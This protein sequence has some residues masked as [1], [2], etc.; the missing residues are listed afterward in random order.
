[1][2]KIKHILRNIKYILCKKSNSFYAK[3]KFILCKNNKNMR[4][5]NSFYA[6][7]KFILCKNN[8]NMRKSNKLYA[9]IIINQHFKFS[10]VY[11][12]KSYQINTS[13]KS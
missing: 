5:S 6:K 8:K 13:K 3:I 9:K 10:S 2:Q 1:M 11:H 4:K 12:K 7:I